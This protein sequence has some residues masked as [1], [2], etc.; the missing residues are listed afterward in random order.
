MR[1]P[2][3]QWTPVD[4]PP[5]LR[6]ITDPPKFLRVRGVVQ[7]GVHFLC[8][9]GSRK[10]SSYG[11]SA[12]EKL[13]EGLRGYPVCIVSGLAL[14]IDA[15][16]HE[17]ALRAGLSTVAVLPS[18][19]ADEAIYPKSHYGLALRITERGGALV[20]EYAD[21]EA[22]QSWSF[23]ARNRIM[24]GLSH[25]TLIIEAG[26]RSG[27]LITAR[28]A[29]EYNRQVLVVPHPISSAGGAGGNALLREGA[30]LVRGSEDILEALDIAPR[31][32]SPSVPANLS[33]EETLVFEALRVPKSRD[34]LSA[35]TGLPAPQLS[36]ALSKLLLKGAAR[37]H[38]GLIE[39]A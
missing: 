15:I 30:T 7:K 37:E 24:A 16:A 20:S 23:P 25:A 4:F 21:T 18:G 19:L 33:P 13:I 8:V 2:I 32:T 14:G 35:E 12:C 36:I 3:E 26:E 31:D 28:L 34:E 1:H 22:P 17:A 6:E 27:T 10:H 5:L 39:R 29:M 9:V 38:L 11:K